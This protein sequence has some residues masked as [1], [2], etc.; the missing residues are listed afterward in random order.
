MKSWQCRKREFYLRLYG[1][2]MAMEDLRKAMNF[3]A[4]SIRLEGYVRKFFEDTAMIWSGALER[5]LTA[6]DVATLLA[7]PLGFGTLKEYS[8][9]MGLEPTGIRIEVDARELKGN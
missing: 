8:I 7:C 4:N 1:D 5:E 3:S 2:L 6:E 9:K